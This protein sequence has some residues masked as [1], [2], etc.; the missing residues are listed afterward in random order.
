[1]NKEQLRDLILRKKSVLCVGLDTD[2]NKIPQFFREQYAG[3]D[4]V[5]EYNKRIIDA[6]LPYAVAFKPN[7]A[8]YESRGL[9]GWESLKK[10]MDY[11]DSK[12][13]DVFCIADAKRGDI[14][15]TSGQYAKAFFDSSQSGFNFDAVTV[16]PYMGVD[17]VSPFLE[18]DNK[19]VII[20]VLTSNPGA[21]DFQTHDFSDGDKLFEKV[22]KTSSQWG[23]SDN[24]MYVIGATRSEMLKR[25]RELVPDHF[26]LIPG[27]GAQGGNLEEV[28]NLGWNNFGGILINASRSIIFAN[29]EEDFAE[30]AAA[31]A[32]KL[33]SI[34]SSFISAQ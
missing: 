30:A 13:N 20:L 31:E 16:A 25:V 28:L 2:I 15:N 5:F 24:T 1:M 4:V 33:Q 23:N 11:I 26:L 12:D 10:T 9:T 32:K 27:V 19:W 18:F 34:M 22:L 3:G 8:F 29:G 14:G 21:D 7:L 17:S 6:V